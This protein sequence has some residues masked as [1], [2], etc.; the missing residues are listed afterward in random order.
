MDSISQH[1]TL[2]SACGETIK[3][4]QNLLEE[5]S[6]YMHQVFIQSKSTVLL[7]PDV[8]IEDLKNLVNHIQIGTVLKQ[9]LHVVAL[10]YG[11]KSETITTS[12][13]HLPL[14]K[15]PLENTP[16]SSP[17]NR[18]LVIDENF[19]PRKS[20]SQSS[21]SVSPN[22]EE[23]LASF[24]PWPLLLQQLS[25][26]KTTQCPQNLL[27]NFNESP[28]SNL[29]SYPPSSIFHGNHPEPSQRLDSDSLISCEDC[30]KMFKTSTL[31]IHRRRVHR[32]LQ[33]PVKCCGQDFPTRWHLSQ[34]K[35]SGDHLPTLWKSDNIKEFKNS[36]ST[37]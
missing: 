28:F 27:Q 1:I 37:Q 12:E 6:T 9:H 29:A 23:S 3:V 7:F 4:S 22:P 18:K 31:A 16:P 34:H 24:L 25:M 15:R 8:D 14:K 2:V 36:I 21:I 17:D 13:T 32:L 11:F 35:K 30:G 19:S 10:K 20:P 26:Q 33:V 5:S